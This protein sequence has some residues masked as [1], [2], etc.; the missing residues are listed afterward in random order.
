MGG[1]WAL[2]LFDRMHLGHHVLI[3][4]LQDMS[5]P[6]AVVTGGELTGD[7]LELGSIIQPPEIR[8]RR[9]RE[10]LE[11]I[12]LVDRIDVQYL[13]GFQELLEIEGPTTFMMYQGPC[14][15]ELEARGLDLREEKLGIKDNLEFLKPVRAHDGDKLSSARIRLGDV[16]REGRRLRGTSEPPRRLEFDSR[17]QLKTPK[18]ELYKASEGAPEKAVAKRIEREEPPLVIAVGDVTSATLIDQGYQPDVCIVDG[19]TKR[20]KFEREFPS[21]RE[22]LIYNPPAVIYP[23]AWSTIDTAIHDDRKTLITVDGEED[24]LGFPA[25]LLAP[26]G[27]VMLYGQPDEG[28]VWVDIEP[29]NRRLARELLDAMPVIE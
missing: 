6:V 13:T 10:Y 21:D 11:S 16:D 26:D 15:V 25:V 4:R 12:E 9:L 14:C 28:I 8:I 7:D 1:T 27:A 19:T 23:E 2:N 20:G 18:G 24:L 5:E 17:M 22:Y 3:D 29:D